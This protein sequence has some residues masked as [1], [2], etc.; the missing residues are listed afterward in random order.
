MKNILK[1]QS[2]SLQHW[3]SQVMITWNTVLR[4][5]FYK[6]E[7]KAVIVIKVVPF[8]SLNKCTAFET[9]E[10]GKFSSLKTRKNS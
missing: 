5:N 4:W 9:T 2:A 3:I 10:F 1:V 7:S 6:G 8:F